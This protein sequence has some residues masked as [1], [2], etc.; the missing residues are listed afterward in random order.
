MNEEKPCPFCKKL[1]TSKNQFCSRKCQNYILAEKRRGKPV[2]Q[3][4]R[5]LLS[6]AKHKPIHAGFKSGKLLAIS[7]A[8]K[9]D[10]E[11]CWNCICDCG[12]K[13]VSREKD[14]RTGGSSSCGCSRKN[15]PKMMGRKNNAGKTYAEIGRGSSPLTG[16]PSPLRGSHRDRAIIEKAIATRQQLILDGKINPQETITKTKSKTIETVKGGVI[17]CN[18]SWEE[19]YARFLDRYSGTIYFGKDKIRIPYFDKENKRRIYIVDFIVY[20]CCSTLLVEIKPE[21]FLNDLN[22]QLKAEAARDWC[23][24]NGATFVFITDDEIAGFNFGELPLSFREQERLAKLKGDKNE[25]N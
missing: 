9:R 7:E 14:L 12:N 18:S 2:S 1:F 6:K 22:V 10:G 25:T 11:Y 20:F 4:T 13:T 5:N 24:K 3:H 17:H 8:P 21:I 23:A 16:R 15:N 19:V